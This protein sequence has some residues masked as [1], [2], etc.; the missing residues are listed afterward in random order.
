MALP[1]GE[2]LTVEAR[3]TTAGAV[4]IAFGQEGAGTFAPILEQ[5]TGTHGRAQ[6]LKA[7]A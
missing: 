1:D 3:R 5:D 4:M 6:I 2:C 7:S